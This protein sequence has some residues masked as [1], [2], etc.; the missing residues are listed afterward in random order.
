MNKNQKVR[1]AVHTRDG[2]TQATDTGFKFRAWKHSETLTEQK[3]YIT[4]LSSKAAKPDRCSCITGILHRTSTITIGNMI[5][6][7]FRK[8]LLKSE[9][10]LMCTGST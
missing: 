10:S 2:G 8:D 9:A 6:W 1:P 7:S 3:Y 4:I 5:P